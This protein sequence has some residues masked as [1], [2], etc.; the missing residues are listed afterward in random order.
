MFR[1]RQRILFIV[2][3]KLSAKSTV[4]QIVQ[5]ENLTLTQDLVW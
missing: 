1:L 4:F 2:A 3:V 5:K